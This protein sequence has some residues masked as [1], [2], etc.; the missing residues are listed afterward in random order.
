MQRCLQSTMLCCVLCEI[1]HCAADELTRN[2]KIPAMTTADH[3][4]RV[5]LPTLVPAVIDDRDVFQ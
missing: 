1:K 5:L 4:L 3:S 2:S